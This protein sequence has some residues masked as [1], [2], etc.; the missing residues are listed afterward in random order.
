M[1]GR[2]I[3]FGAAAS[4]AAGGAS[5]SGAPPA[6]AASVKLLLARCQKRCFCSVNL[7]FMR[8]PSSCAETGDG[9]LSG[10]VRRV[11]V[12]CRVWPHF[13]NARCSTRNQD[14]A[15]SGHPAGRPRSRHIDSKP[16]CVRYDFRPPLASRHA[17]FALCRPTN[18]ARAPVSLASHSDNHHLL[19]SFSHRLKGRAFSSRRPEDVPPPPSQAQLFSAPRRGQ[20]AASSRRPS[21]ELLM[22]A[23]RKCCWQLKT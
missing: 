1:R 16:A 9:P 22:R 10:R 15:F 13:T 14:Q 8:A 4:R 2:A 12:V 7:N 11:Q 23:R 6:A 21:D 17:N 20:K 3:E 5:C 19:A 18:C